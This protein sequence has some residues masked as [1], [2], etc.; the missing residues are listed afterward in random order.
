[1][2][3]HLD[4]IMGIL[5]CFKVALYCWMKG[6]MECLLQMIAVSNCN[7]CINGLTHGNNHEC[8]RVRNGQ[9]RYERRH[10]INHFGEAKDMLLHLLSS[11]TF[12]P[13][14]QKIIHAMLKDHQHH[15]DD[16][17]YSVNTPQHI[18][19]MACS[20]ECTNW[21]FNRLWVHHQDPIVIRQGILNAT[22]QLQPGVN[23]QQQQPADSHPPGVNQQP[24]D[25][26]QSGV[27]QQ[28]QQPA[29]SQQPG[30]N[31]Q[32]GVN[33]QHADNQ[34]QTPVISSTDDDITPIS[35]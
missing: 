11:P 13:Q 34:Q 8:Y 23:Q 15:T 17:I 35:I 12:I 4:N 28:Q 20:S 30:V 16:K 31:Q 7:Q 21:V 9:V 29:D 1:M 14:L 6:Q 24:A 3:V 33:Q 27:N 32:S 26:Q 19:D 22:S 18:G 5:R 25:D 2:I 10:I